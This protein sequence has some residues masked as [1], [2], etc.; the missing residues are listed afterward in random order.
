MSQNTII[1]VNPIN[2]ELVEEWERDPRVDMVFER[3]ELQDD[4]DDATT[5]SEETQLLM[6][7]PETLVFYD[8][9]DEEFS[10]NNL[11]GSFSSPI[12]SPRR[13]TIRRTTREWTLSPMTPPV[14]RRINFFVDDTLL[15]PRFSPDGSLLFYEEC[16]RSD[17]LQKRDPDFKRKYEENGGSEHYFPSQKK[18][19]EDREFYRECAD[20]LILPYSDSECDE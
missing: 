6:A 15:I 2:G 5:V 14:R 20:E 12:S 1:R 9:V 3:E 17:V 11:R 19:K 4:S 10:F 18:M 7:S 13:N 16:E 8:H